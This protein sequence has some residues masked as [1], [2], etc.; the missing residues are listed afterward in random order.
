VQRDDIDL[1]DICAPGGLHS[2]IALAALAAGKHV[3]CEKPL[4]NTVPEAEAMTEAANA[5]RERGVRSMVG[6]SYRRTP[7][8]A[9]AREWVAEDGW[10]PSGTSGRLP[11]GLDRDRTPVGV[12]LRRRRP[13]PARSATSARTSSTSPSSSPASWSRRQRVDRDVVKE[14]PLPS[15]A[16]GLAAVAGAPAGEVTVD[17]ASCS[18]ARCDG[19]ALATSRPPGRHGRKNGCASSLKTDRPA[20]WPRLRGVQ[21]AVLLRR[22]ENPEQAGFKRVLVTE[23]GHLPVRMVAARHGLGYDHTFTKPGS[24]PAD[25]DRRGTPTPQPSFADGCRFA[26]PGRPWRPARRNSS[27]WTTV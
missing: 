14:R 23:P 26:R 11:A 17:A 2:E 6:F 5:A 15:S 12:R 10:Q 21:R 22:H 25:R 18:L 27:T 20:A 7:A 4:A 19:G 9:L 13:G 24:R 1:I 16:S 3:L 8:L